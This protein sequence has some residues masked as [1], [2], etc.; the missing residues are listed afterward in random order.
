MDIKLLASC[1]VISLYALSGCKTKGVQGNLKHDFGELSSS[2][3]Q[4][5]CV[6]QV[7][8]GRDAAYEKYVRGHI[9][10][11]V[12]ANR[13][14]L[15][16]VFSANKFC[17]NVY[18]DPNVNAAGRDNGMVTVFHGAVL[19]FDTDA[20]FAAV[21]SHELAHIINSAEYLNEFKQLSGDANYQTIIAEIKSDLQKLAQIN[22]KVFVN[23][24]NPVT[25][26]KGAD[27]VR[28]VELYGRLL[29][30]YLRR[31]AQ[32][33][34]PPDPYQAI[35]NNRH[36][37]KWDPPTEDFYD[38]PLNLAQY[39]EPQILNDVQY[40]RGKLL[41]GF[42]ADEMPLLLAAEKQAIQ[43][44]AMRVFT[45]I[46]I[47]ELNQKKTKY[48]R[49][50]LGVEI[51]SNWKEQSADEIGYEM[52]LRAGFAKD[53][54]PLMFYKMRVY[55]NKMKGIVDSNINLS[56]DEAHCQRGTAEHP[57]MCWRML[58]LDR[59]WVKHHTEYEKLVE[60]GSALN[61]FGD[62]LAQ[63]KILYKKN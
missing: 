9:E 42:T 35:L 33:S 53:E 57:E 18:D 30:F 3:H 10:R 16:E 7:Y 24:L 22:E 29:Y 1:C 61:V 44:E 13:E 32:D 6:Q 15:P 11:I 43:S 21:L 58:D 31:C 51:G 20:D 28:R 47:D 62:A 54:F 12:S 17:V 5:D 41:A 19:G 25:A 38:L 34:V 14:K 37:P 40:V 4:L 50:K 2:P 39:A 46:N 63:L 27:T 60:G 59:E 23:S 36:E 26:K 8:T 48:E 45:T 49:E 55:N 56:K 52:Y